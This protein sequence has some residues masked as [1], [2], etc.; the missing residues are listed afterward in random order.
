MIGSIKDENGD[1]VTSLDI[2]VLRYFTRQISYIVAIRAYGR[3]DVIAGD[4]FIEEKPE[5]WWSDK[6]F[7]T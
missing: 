6:L 4:V 3:N 7:K 2:V 1:P 5:V